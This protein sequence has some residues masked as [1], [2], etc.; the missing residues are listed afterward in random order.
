MS[1]DWVILKMQ[2]SVHECP[3]SLWRMFP[4]LFPDVCGL[5]S[6]DCVCVVVTVQQAHCELLEV[7]AESDMEKD[8]LLEQFV[9]WARAVRDRVPLEYW[10]EAIDPCSGYPMFGQR[11]S[12]VYGEVEWCQTLLKYPSEQVGNCRVLRHPQWGTNMYPATLFSNAPRDLLELAIR[13]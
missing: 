10:V 12:G 13:L 7:S 8:R 5:L 2:A 9:H 3:K 1:N 11:G 4:T 6:M